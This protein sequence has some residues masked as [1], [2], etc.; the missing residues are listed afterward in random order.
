MDRPFPDFRET[1]ATPSHT[2]EVLSS[3]EE[4]TLLSCQEKPI[5]ANVNARAKG[6]EPSTR[7]ASPLPAQDQEAILNTASSRMSSRLAFWHPTPR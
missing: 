5:P 6:L 2:Q 7:G 1:A 3:L 4:A